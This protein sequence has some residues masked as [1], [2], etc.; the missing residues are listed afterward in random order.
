MK[1]HT[2]NTDTAR[3]MSHRQNPLLAKS[4]W[5]RVNELCYDYGYTLQS[6]LSEIVSLVYLLNGCL[7]LFPSDGG[8]ANA[9]RS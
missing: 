4:E 2:S 8:Q 1:M 3:V 9:Q 6:A 5:L 7:H